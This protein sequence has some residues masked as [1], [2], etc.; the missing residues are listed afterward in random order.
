MSEDWAIC[1]HNIDHYCT[2]KISC[3]ANGCEYLGANKEEPEK[4]KR[5]NRQT[6]RQQAKGKGIRI[7]GYKSK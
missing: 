6:R 5:P 7:G 1:P 2:S 4:M 3:S